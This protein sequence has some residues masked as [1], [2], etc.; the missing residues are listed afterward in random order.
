MKDRNFMIEVGEK[1]QAEVIERN[2]RPTEASVKTNEKN[3]RRQ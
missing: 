1:P 2:Q 3:R